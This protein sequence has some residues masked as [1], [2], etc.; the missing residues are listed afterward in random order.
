MIN[1]LFYFLL[2]QFSLMLNAQSPQFDWAKDYG[3]HG[4]N[5]ESSVK[6]TIGNDGSVYNIGSYRGTADFDPSLSVSNLIAVGMTDIYFTK[7]DTAGNLIWAK[8]IGSFDFEF[9]KSI[10][11]DSLGN[12]FVIGMF[13]NTCDFDPSN[14]SY[15][16]TSSGANDCFIAKYDDTGNFLW[17]KTFGAINNDYIS[18]SCL[19]RMGNIYLTGNFDKTIDFDFGINS[20]Q[21][22]ADSGNVFLLKL[23]NNGD[24]QWLNTVGGISLNGGSMANA[25]D[26]KINSLNEI[27]FSGIFRDTIDFDPSNINSYNLISSGGS[28]PFDQFIVKYD[29]QG[30]F[31]NAAKYGN[32]S[33]DVP[34]KIAIDKNDNIFA[35]CTD[36]Y[37][38][39]FPFNSINKRFRFMYSKIENATLHQLWNKTISSSI[40]ILAHSIETDKNN[41]IYIGG[42]FDGSVDFDEDVNTSYIQATP[43]QGSF[44]FFL[45][46]LDTLGRFNFLQRYGNNPVDYSYGTI[47]DIKI[48]NLKQ[49]YLTG[50]FTYTIDFNTD[51]LLTFNLN[52]NGLGDV[53]IMKMNPINVVNGIIEHNF[54]ENTI[55][56]YP[57]PTSDNVFI[58]IK[59]DAQL[60]VINSIGEEILSENLVCGK[61]IINLNNLASG[62]YFINISNSNQQQTFK[63]IKQ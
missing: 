30:N 16:V 46:G 23:N 9:P 33:D 54:N 7:S 19:D 24:F 58:E 14:S 63:I 4:A 22:N 29:L 48:N 44:D 36:V 52:S 31:L 18:S 20:Y 28:F 35:V 40:N 32:N 60:I 10:E 61:N 57:N 56:I 17:V 12:V 59:K 3:D 62:I 37:Y 55:L 53:Y 25:G 42:S 11:V 21:A 38:I 6:L 27:V 43:G 41:T 47:D 45:L 8:S 13:N 49:I 15:F 26:I 34:F 39:N 2:V 51:T 1:K 5:N 50:S